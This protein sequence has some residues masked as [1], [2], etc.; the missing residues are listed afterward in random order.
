MSRQPAISVPSSGDARPEKS[1]SCFSPLRVMPVTGP[2]LP[3]L[4]L[5]WLALLWLALLW[6][7]WLCVGRRPGARAG[8]ERRP[9]GQ[10]HERPDDGA[11]ADDGARAYRLNHAGT[12][13][14]R[15]VPY[16]AARPDLSP[17][18]HGCAALQLSTRPD[19]RPGVQGHADID[20]GAGGIHDRHASA[21]PGCQQALVQDPPRTGQLGLIIHP[22]NLIK[23]LTPNGPHRVTVA[24]KDR[25]DIGEVLL[26]LGIVG[27]KPLHRVGQ[28]VAVE[29]VH[30]RVDLVDQPLPGAGV[31]FLDDPGERS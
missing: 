10:V 11:L 20:P 25:D 24:A 22:Q 3:S 23:V 21:H 31:C 5:L 1:I 13:R 9:R 14:D 8:R 16:Q 2:A 29:G 15:G 6:P 19:L 18:R 12:G 17:G 4:A 28:Q 26:A 30:A 7:A 27:R